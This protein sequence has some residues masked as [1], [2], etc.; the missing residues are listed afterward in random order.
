MVDVTSCEKRVAQL[1]YSVMIVVI[2]ERSVDSEG[3]VTA[4][5]IVP[6]DVSGR[7]RHIRW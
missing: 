4:G 3:K 5:K 6:E 7:N 1:S 2:R